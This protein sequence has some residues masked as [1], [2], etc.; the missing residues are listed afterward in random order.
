LHDELYPHLPTLKLDPERMKDTL[1][2]LVGN[3]ID[4]CAEVGGGRVTVATDL[5]QGTGEVVITVTDN[6]PG[7]PESIRDTLFRPFTSTKGPRG[8]GLGLA[9]VERNVIAHEGKIFLD[10]NGQDGSE[11]QVRL[12][13]RSKKS[14]AFHESAL[15]L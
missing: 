3:A 4:A 8:T 5:F 7:I 6:G 11:F 10:S 9:I 15:A 14:L 13:L 1:L 12:P 2:N